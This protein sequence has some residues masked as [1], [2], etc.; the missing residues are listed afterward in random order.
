MPRDGGIDRRR[1]PNGRL[2]IWGACLAFVDGGH[3]FTSQPGDQW[4]LWGK[5]TNHR[6]QGRTADIG[7]ES[8]RWPSLM[9]QCL[10][11][12]DTQSPTGSPLL[13]SA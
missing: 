9:N 1:V 11:R 10:S 3:S 13:M 6:D 2:L 8:G 12:R 7:F 4:L 5:N